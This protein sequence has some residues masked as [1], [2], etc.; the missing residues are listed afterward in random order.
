MELNVKL[1]Q[2]LDK[3]ENIGLQLTFAHDK[4][5]TKKG[6]IRKNFLFNFFNALEDVIEPIA[7]TAGS[8]KLTFELL[9]DEFDLPDFIKVKHFYNWRKKL[10]ETKALEQQTQAQALAVTTVST[11]PVVQATNLN[12]P[13]IQKPI[14]S[15]HQSSNQQPIIDVNPRPLQPAKPINAPFVNTSRPQAPFDPDVAAKLVP[16]NESCLIRDDAKAKGIWPQAA[17]NRDYYVLPGEVTNYKEVVEYWSHFDPPTGLPIPRVLRPLKPDDPLYPYL[18]KQIRGGDAKFGLDYSFLVDENGFVYDPFM[19]SA[20]TFGV[21]VPMPTYC[22][23]MHDSVGYHN[24]SMPIGNYCRT[25]TLIRDLTEYTL[26][27][28]MLSNTVSYSF[29]LL[30]S[31]PLDRFINAKAG[32]FPTPVDPNSRRRF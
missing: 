5:A 11:R 23:Y 29:K 8:A 6:R 9:V 25:Q 2:I 1:Q 7:K 27:R 10:E 24:T 16:W 20:R 19:V 3:P 30:T 21:P 18:D 15:V 26:V 17:G 28:S 32:V 22:D 13:Q 31:N 12:L 14:I 4:Y